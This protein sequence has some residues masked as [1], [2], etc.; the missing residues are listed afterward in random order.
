MMSERSLKAAR[1]VSSI[2]A[3]FMSLA[4]GTN[5][6]IQIIAISIVMLTGIVC[7][8]GMGTPIRREVE[9]LLNAK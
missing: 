4:C 6:R 5:V 3:T 1:I 9:A 2:A 7:L 8:F